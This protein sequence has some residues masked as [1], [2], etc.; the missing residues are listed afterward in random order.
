MVFIRIVIYIYMKILKRIVFV[1]LVLLNL[2][3][4]FLPNCFYWIWTGKDF[5]A[6]R[7]NKMYSKWIYNT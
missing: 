3:V 5:M 1:I 4:L 6:D 7:L 2:I